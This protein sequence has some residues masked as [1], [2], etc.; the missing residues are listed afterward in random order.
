[1][2][3]LCQ[4]V[5]SV[6]GCGFCAGVWV[7]RHNRGGGWLVR[8]IKALCVGIVGTMSAMSAVSAMSVV[9]AFGSDRAMKALC[10]G[11]VSNVGSVVGGQ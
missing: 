1:M 11:N 8:A 4:G 6:P 3:V 7:L 9:S 5:G 2:W 10:V